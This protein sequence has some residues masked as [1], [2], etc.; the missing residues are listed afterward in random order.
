MRKFIFAFSLLF[1][2]LSVSAQQQRTVQLDDLERLKEISDPELSLDGRWILYTVSTITKEADHRD[3]ELWE[4]S[5]DGTQTI[6]LTSGHDGVGEARWSPDGKYVSFLSSRTGA[7]KGSQIW[8][9]DRRGGEASQLTALKGR[10]RSY[11]W[12]PDSQSIALVFHE[13]EGTASERRGARTGAEGDAVHEELKPVVVNRYAFKR[14]GQ[15][16]VAD[17]DHS[18]I[19]FFTLAAGKVVPLTA[20]ADVDEENP[21][22]SHDGTKIAFV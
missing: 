22:W 17:D 19:Y 20:R 5:W 3:T 16:Y 14:D 13:G 8:V 11:A 1:A 10:I 18:R 15:G 6:Q 21:T 4:V 7:A 12:S 2:A 9:L